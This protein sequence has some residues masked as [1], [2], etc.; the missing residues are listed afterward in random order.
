MK[1]VE[2]V[3]D[4]VVFVLMKDPA[5]VAKHRHQ[6][7]TDYAIVVVVQF[8]RIA[9]IVIIVN[10]SVQNADIAMEGVRW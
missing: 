6:I 8:A 2:D 7:V 10:G 9:E 3:K 5:L 4:H 1:I